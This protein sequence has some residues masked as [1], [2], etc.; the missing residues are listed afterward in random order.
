MNFFI[1][2]IDQ[3]VPD[4]IAEDETVKA[5]QKEMGAKLRPQNWA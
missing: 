1:I 2:Y 4:E 3:L 5:F